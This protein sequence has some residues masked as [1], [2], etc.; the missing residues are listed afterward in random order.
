[1]GI[2]VAQ[3]AGACLIVAEKGVADLATIHRTVEAIGRRNFIGSVLIS[4]QRL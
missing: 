1:M 3:S 2:P 4:P